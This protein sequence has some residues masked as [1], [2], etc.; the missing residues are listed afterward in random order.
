[1]H[2]D[3]SDFM[4]LKKKVKKLERKYGF[5]ANPV[6]DQYFLIDEDVVRRIVRYGKINNKDT[7]M[8]IGP[9]LGFITRK[10]AKRAGKVKAVEKAENL[11]PVL[12]EEV[13][14]Y[15]NVE[16]TWKDCMKI[17][18]PT[19]NKVI[20][21]LPFSISGPLTFKLADYEFEKAVLVY[22]KE[23]GEKMK[24]KPGDSNY[25]RL[26]VMA[27]HYF[28]I[29]LREIVKRSSYYPQPDVDTAIVVLTPRNVEKDKGFDEFIRQVFRYRNKNLSNAVKLGFKIDIDD[30]RKVKELGLPELKEVYGEIKNRM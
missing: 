19:F 30:D 14:E 22:Q 5:R 2:R 3:T 8:E 27:Q 4:S 17:K 7:V 18:F 21:S 12:E 9:G 25:G 23:F 16:F 24:A 29:K 10:I 15:D 11:K 20:S 6:L 13:R 26:S 28:N 1:M